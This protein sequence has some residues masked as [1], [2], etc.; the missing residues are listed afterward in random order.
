M[1]K[2][3]R[4]T[5]LA[6]IPAMGTAAIVPAT[7][8]PVENEH[9]WEKVRRLAREL[10]EALCEGDGAWT[11]PGGKW[12]ADIYPAD[13]RDG[14]PIGFGNIRA[15]ERPRRN[16]SLPWQNL[17]AAHKDAWE[18]FG[19][20]VDECDL[21][22]GIEPSKAAQRRWDRSNRAEERALEAICAFRPHGS[23][24]A[25]AKAAFIAPYIRRGELT[26]DQ[27]MALNYSTVR[28]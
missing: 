15:K 18:A 10:S 4:R 19:R 16:V 1:E 2:I 12:C 26:S 23:A 9:P 14:Y 22:P 3:T 11:G 21:G 13:Q 17:V 8:Q 7:A 5:A 6:A 27:I 20:A 24:D 28:S 25:R